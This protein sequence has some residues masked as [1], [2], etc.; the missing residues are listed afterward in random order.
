MN[1]S[2][3]IIRPYLRNVGGQVGSAETN[4]TVTVNTNT[5]TR[6]GFYPPSPRLWWTSWYFRLEVDNLYTAAYPQVVVE[7]VYD[8]G[9]NEPYV[10][11]SETGNVFV[12]ESPE[13][14]S[15][16]YD[17]NLLSDGRFNYTWARKIV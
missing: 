8:P 9:T 14:F 16:D 17:G 15:Y 4:V 12:A 10:V 1:K 5:A 13:T 2:S 6:Q 7:A 11:S 3:D